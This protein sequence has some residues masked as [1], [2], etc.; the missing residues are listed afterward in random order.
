MGCSGG[1]AFSFCFFFHLFFFTKLRSCMLKTVAGKRD[2]GQCEVS[3]LL[4]SEPLYH[5]SFEYWGLKSRLF[6]TGV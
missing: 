1:V 5:S 6:V 4:M 2:L 3:R